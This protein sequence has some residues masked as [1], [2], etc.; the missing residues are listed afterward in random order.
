MQTHTGQK[1]SSSAA[2]TQIAF[3]MMHEKHSCE[4][5]GSFIIFNV[6]KFKNHLKTLE[7]N[8][9]FKVWFNIYEEVKLKKSLSEK[10]IQLK[11]RC[12]IFQ[13]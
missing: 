7:K 11:S 1:Q 10:H 2:F 5:C 12:S 6:F 4:V 13:N 9:N 8:I 3:K